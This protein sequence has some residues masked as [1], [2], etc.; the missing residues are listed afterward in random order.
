MQA[1]TRMQSEI[2]VEQYFKQINEECEQA[3]DSEASRGHH[4]GPFSSQLIEIGKKYLDELLDK[5]LS[6]EKT[7][8][9]R[10]ASLPSGAYYETLNGEFIRIA[11]GFIEAAYSRIS[12]HMVPEMAK[13]AFAKSCERDKLKYSSRIA[14]KINI[15]QEELKLEIP[16]H[17]GTVI[18]VRGDVG[19]I[20][21]GTVYGS[22]H[23]HIEKMKETSIADAELFDKLLTAIKESKM[24]DTEIKEQMEH[25]EY[26]VTQYET[27]KET[28]KNGLINTSLQMLA[29]ASNLSTV[30]GQIGPAI[31]GL[32]K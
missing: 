16:S 29:V 15:M 6:A 21:T 19:A 3:A 17:G 12:L 5:L 10:A 31:E 1:Y 23:G 13:Q 18:N 14:N 7:A 2:L 25:V 8:L 32:F 20:N 27:P 30:W 28:R 26:L 9:S 22:I 24:S 11:N 4:S